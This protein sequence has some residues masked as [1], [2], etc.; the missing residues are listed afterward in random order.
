MKNLIT[1]QQA[2]DYLGVKLSTIRK[3]GA[4]GYVPRIKI[5]GAVRFDRDA[6][7]EWVEKRSTKGRMQLRT[8]AYD[9]QAQRSAQR[10]ITLN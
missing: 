10:P 9:S 1:A 5:G 4:N 6:L 7:D 3:W 8:S 2:A